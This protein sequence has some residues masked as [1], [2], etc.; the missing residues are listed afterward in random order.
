MQPLSPT[1]NGFVP[2]S[3][4]CISTCLDMPDPEQCHRHL[5]E[6]SPASLGR[7]APPEPPCAG[8]SALIARKR[9]KF[10]SIPDPQHCPSA[11][12]EASLNY[13]VRR[14]PRQGLHGLHDFFADAFR[15][16]PELIRR[17]RGAEDTHVVRS[18]CQLKHFAA[19]RIQRDQRVVSL[20]QWLCRRRGQR[21]Q[22][23]FESEFASTRSGP[24]PPRDAAGRHECCPR[25][26]GSAR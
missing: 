22:A 8:L 21:R 17:S 19:V 26:A 15:Q 13:R 6:K 4:C 2:M 25:A 16:I 12:A 5:L 7:I 14:T 1:T 3:I 9:F 18:N 23:I 24:W 11:R 20:Q 10:W